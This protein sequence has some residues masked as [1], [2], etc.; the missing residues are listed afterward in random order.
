MHYFSVR[1]K[2]MEGAKKVYKWGKRSIKG[3]LSFSLFYLMLTSILP[4]IN[5][6]IPITENRKKK[7]SV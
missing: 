6:F 5:E 7:L 2:K 4:R 3:F 1:Q